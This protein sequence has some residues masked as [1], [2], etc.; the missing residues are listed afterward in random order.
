MTE[1]LQDFTVS[2]DRLQQ[3]VEERQRAEIALKESEQR[4]A[5]T[6]SSIGDAVIATDVAG[7]I[8]FMNAVAEGFDRLGLT[9]GSRRNRDRG[10]QRSSTNRPG[11]RG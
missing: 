6:L 2:K 7:K 10:L 1:R 5:T 3:E 4:W 9:R 11:S 8:T